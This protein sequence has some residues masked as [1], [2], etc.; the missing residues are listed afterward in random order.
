M[1][2]EEK[3]FPL[4]VAYDFLR[5]VETP[6]FVLRL[7]AKEVEGEEAV[8]SEGEERCFLFIH[9]LLS[10]QVFSNCRYHMKQNR[11]QAVKKISQQAMKKIHE[12]DGKVHREN[13]FFETMKT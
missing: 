7:K 2:P 1:L 13:D 11:C 9:F 5:S 4:G 8:E 10:S 3:H 12:T 6:F